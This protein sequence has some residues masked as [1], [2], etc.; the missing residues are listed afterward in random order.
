[1]KSRC[2]FTAL[3]ASAIATAACGG[4]VPE[5]RY[6]QLAGPI[7]KAAPGELMIVLESLE[8]DSGYDDDRIV[9]RS[10]PYRLDYY[11]YHRWS[12]A[13]GV[14]IGNF[15]EQA[16]ERSGK[17]RAVI[18]EVSDQSPVV[19]RGRVLAIEEVDTSKTSW[20]G[21]IVLELTLTDSKTGEALWSEQFEETEPLSV[22]T[23]EGL[24]QALTIVM[25]RI[26]ARATPAIAEHADR[27]ARIHAALPKLAAGG[28]K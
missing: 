12:A 7:A 20:L 2:V 21:R 10:T 5:T 28:S 26:A 14:M 9:Y 18:R 16:L 27:Q 6:Y 15:L 19:I 23:P 4:K 3:I 11:Q 13:P 17:F 25:T 8:T 24:A 1:M 22:Q